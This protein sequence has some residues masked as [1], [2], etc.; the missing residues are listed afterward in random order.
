MYVGVDEKLGAK[1]KEDCGLALA[2]AKAM[3]RP[4]LEKEVSMQDAIMGVLNA[5]SYQNLFKPQITSMLTRLLYYPVASG[6]SKK[7]KL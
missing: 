6:K 2:L 7:P 4:A 3:R 1:S 5:F